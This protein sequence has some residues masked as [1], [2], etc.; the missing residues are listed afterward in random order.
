[1]QNATILRSYKMTS[2]RGFAP[3]PY[4]GV[5]TLATCKPFIRKCRAVLGQWLAGFTSKELNPD[6]ELGNERLIYLAK[7]T[8]VLPMEQY[9]NA[10]PAKRNC[11]SPDN[12]YRKQNGR[13]TIVNDSIHSE[14]NMDADTSGENVLISDDYY[15]FGQ[16]ALPIGKELRSKIQIPRGA[17]PYGWLTT[18]SD[19]DAVIEWVKKEAQKMSSVK[20][21]P[22]MFGE[23]HGQ[24]VLGKNA[25]PVGACGRRNF[26]PS[27]SRKTCP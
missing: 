5:L 27:P 17:S 12:I 9:W 6:D 16:K 7:I 1:M 14:E 11:P 2:D 3:N 24:V 21:H 26:R 13:W 19:A 8:A 15:Y 18:D 25:N 22:H 20:N 4:A 10:Y 23:P